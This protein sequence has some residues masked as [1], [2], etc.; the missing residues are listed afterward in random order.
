MRFSSFELQY[1]HDNDIQGITI[2]QLQGK[3]LGNI[4]ANS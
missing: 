2:A 4:F 3:D 1:I